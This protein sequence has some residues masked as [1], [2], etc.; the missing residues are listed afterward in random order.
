VIDQ[1]NKEIGDIGWFTLEQALTL[2]RDRHE[3]RKQVLIDLHTKLVSWINNYF[4]ENHQLDQ[5]MFTTNRNRAYH[6][7]NDLY[8]SSI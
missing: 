6:S 5:E 4:A 8:S 2:I 7:I 1:N 3:Q